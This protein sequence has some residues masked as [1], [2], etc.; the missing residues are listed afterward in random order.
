MDKGYY[1]EAY[2]KWK[3]N[4]KSAYEYEKQWDKA[5][6]ETL[7]EVKKQVHGMINE[8]FYNKPVTEPGSSSAIEM[9]QSVTYMILENALKEAR[10]K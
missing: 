9:G 8:K 5:Y 1:D 10:G 4:N 2:E 6:S 3:E 7:T